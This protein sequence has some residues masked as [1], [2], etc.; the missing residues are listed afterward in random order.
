MW[1]QYIETKGKSGEPI[2]T[3]DAQELRRLYKAWLDATDVGERAEIWRKI[4]EINARDVF[5]IGLV[6]GV[7]Q[8][9]VVSNKLHNVPEEGIFN[10]IPG[11]FFGYYHMD[12]F[13]L[14]PESSNQASTTPTKG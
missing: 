14:T 6:A 3:P 12:T 2:D 5:S 7:P 9:I 10:W 1:G 8:P 13:W 11:A 4:L